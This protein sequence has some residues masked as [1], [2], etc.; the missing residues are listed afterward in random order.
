MSEVKKMVLGNTLFQT[1]VFAKTACGEAQ[2]CDDQ[3][4]QHNLTAL[5]EN[6]WLELL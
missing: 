6:R 5:E 2:S 1:L 4:L 3:E